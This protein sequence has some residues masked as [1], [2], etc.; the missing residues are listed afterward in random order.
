[1]VT[2]EELRSYI[3]L[4]DA[5]EDIELSLRELEEQKNSISATKFQGTPSGSGSPDKFA[6]I[7]IKIEQLKKQYITTAAEK[8]DKLMYIEKAINKLPER[9]RLLIRY[10]YIDNYSW[11]NIANKMNYSWQWTHEIHSRALKMLLEEKEQTQTD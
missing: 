10:R 11:I 1:M 2:K 6:E 9:E 7:M 5:V 8:L 3:Y 4:K